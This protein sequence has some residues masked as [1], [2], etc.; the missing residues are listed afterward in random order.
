[1]IWCQ[2]LAYLLFFCNTNARLFVSVLN[3]TL[4]EAGSISVFCIGAD[5]C[6]QAMYI[7]CLQSCEVWSRIEMIVMNR[8]C[9]L[10]C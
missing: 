7:D 4:S 10:L 6:F 1:M 5:L 9:S 2:K 3:L 8:F